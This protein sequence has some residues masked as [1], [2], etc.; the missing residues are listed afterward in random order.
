MT[1]PPA[2]AHAVPLPMP[3]VP[4]AKSRAAGLLRVL[5][6]GVGGGFVG[7]LAASLGLD[8]LD[9]ATDG[10]RGA[11]WLGPLIGT[12]V[13]VPLAVVLHELGHVAGGRLAGFR[14]ELLVVGPVRVRRGER[15]LRWELNRR[16][17]LWGGLALCVPTAADPPALGRVLFIAGGPAASVLATAALWGLAAGLP[18]AAPAGARAGVAA[19]GLMNAAVAL[20]SLVPSAAGGF[21]SDGRRLLTLLAGG[22]AARREAAVWRVTA[23]DIL[24]ARPRD[25]PEDAL[26]AGLEPDDG[27]PMAWAARGLCRTAAED[28]GDRA[29]TRRWLEEEIR[30][31]P[32]V[33]P[34]VHAGTALAA[35]RYEAGVRRDPAA[36]ELWRAKTAGGLA[37]PAAE[38]PLTDAVVFFAKGDSEAAREAVAKAEAAGADGALGAGT[39]AALRDRLQE[40][41][42][43]LAA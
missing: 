14:F 32:H 28:R 2:D 15:G 22:A 1:E 41:K 16:G 7:Y 6:F 11:G 31:L 29:A 5:A 33:S 20:A 17:G 37:V 25:W 10:L 36:A 3:P 27:S 4:A 8:W 42:A 34:A 39:A 13:G 24:G 40:L 35:M 38:P 43:K 19:A 12:I 23:A 21:Q 9:G 18:D 30:R 26:A